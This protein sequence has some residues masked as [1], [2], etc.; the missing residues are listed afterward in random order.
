MIRAN[1]KSALYGAQEILPHF[2]ARG[3]GHVINISSMLG[4]MPLAMFRSAYI[5]AKHFLNA[6]T[7]TLAWRCRRRIRTS[8][9]RSCRRPWSTPNSACTRST[10]A[11]IRASWPAD[12]CGRRRRRDRR[13]DRI[14]AA[15]CVYARGIQGRRRGLFHSHGGGSVIRRAVEL[16]VTVLLLSSTAAAQGIEMG[17]P[18]KAQ[19][20]SVYLQLERQLVKHEY[21]FLRTDPR[22]RVIIVRAPKDSAIVRM[23]VVDMGDSSDARFSASR[24]QNDVL[25]MTAPADRGQRRFAQE[26][27]AGAASG[28]S[29]RRGAWRARRLVDI[30]RQY[31]PAGAG[32][33]R[34]PTHDL[35]RARGHWR[36]QC[37]ARNGGDALRLRSIQ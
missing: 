31:P 24:R 27:R 2:K 7:A 20:D 14:A 16:G 17:S 5:G 29:D 19:A 35:D 26:G 12:R 1:V 36:H 23:H 33:G 13:R 6:L 21:Y 34:R 22:A 30:Q 18:S 37:V 10:A 25:T 8:S 4:R 3:T 9:S 32:P 11:P 28:S 15:G